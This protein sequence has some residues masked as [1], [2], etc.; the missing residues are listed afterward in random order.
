MV[1]EGEID[2]IGITDFSPEEDIV[3]KT[4]QVPH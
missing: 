1:F 2:F 4:R 3:K